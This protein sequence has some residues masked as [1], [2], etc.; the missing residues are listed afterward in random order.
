MICGSGKT[1]LGP[2]DFVFFA[3]SRSFSVWVFVLPAF[4][5]ITD[6]EREHWDSVRLV[7]SGKLVDVL[8]SRW[9]GMIHGGLMAPEF[10]S[11]YSWKPLRTIGMKCAELG[12]QLEKTNNIYNRV[13]PL[14]DSAWQFVYTV[15]SDGGEIMSE[16]S[17]IPCLTLSEIRNLPWRWP[18]QLG[19][20]YPLVR[21]DLV[22]ILGGHIFLLSEQ[23]KRLLTTLRLKHFGGVPLL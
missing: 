2:R 1:E 18:S 13:T 19:A 6:E 7:D 16:D 14:S 5:H 4:I 23:G 10:T 15:N 11:E 21:R 9:A 17:H 8:G 12:M 22:H 20:E 3:R